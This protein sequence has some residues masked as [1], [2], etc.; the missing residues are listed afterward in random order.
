MLDIFICRF[1]TYRRAIDW[2][3]GNEGKADS[4]LFTKTFNRPLD[5]PSDE[6]PEPEANL[7]QWQGLRVTRRALRNEEW[8]Q[9]L[10]KNYS[11]STFDRIFF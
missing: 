7:E 4:F 11:Q 1:R 2:R 3:N 9:Y 6:E 8:S 10:G 5:V